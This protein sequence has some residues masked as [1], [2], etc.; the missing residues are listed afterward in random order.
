MTADCDVGPRIR[1]WTKDEI[2]IFGLTDEIGMRS[3]VYISLAAVF[4]FLSDHCTMVR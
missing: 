4:V 3:V 2:V 1:S